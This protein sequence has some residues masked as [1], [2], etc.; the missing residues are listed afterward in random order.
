LSEIERAASLTHEHLL[1]VIATEAR[2]LPAERR[3]EILDLGCGEGR[4]LGYFARNLPRVLPGVRPSLYGLEAH[5]VGVQRSAFMERASAHLASVAPETRWQER[6][7]GISSTERWPFPDACFDFIVSNQVLEHVKDH[8]LVFSE[9]RRTLK[10][11]GRAVHLFPLKHCWY[12]GHLWLMW[13]HRIQNADLRAAYVR[14]SSRLGLGKYRGHRS[15]FGMSLEQYS[16]MHSDYIQFMTNY[17]TESEVLAHA[18]QAGLRASFTYTQELYYR[19]LRQL[20]RRPVP[21]RYS[22]RRNALA[23]WLWLKALRYVSGVTLYL[24][25]KQSYVNPAEAAGHC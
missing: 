20:L 3:L 5:D 4:M 7:F 2:E 23:D 8:W 1:C 24:E 15:A 19:K 25:K 18:K 9:M 6:L 21:F 12:E 22:S 17:L 14:L 13:V 16:E 10:E 11:G